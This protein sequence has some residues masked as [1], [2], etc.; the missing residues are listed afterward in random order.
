MCCDFLPQEKGFDRSLFF[1]S[2]A[3]F[4]S[5]TRCDL[6]LNHSPLCL[7]VGYRETH[8]TNEVNCCMYYCCCAAWNIRQLLR[9]FMFCPVALGPYHATC[10]FPN[11][12]LLYWTH[13]EGTRE[14][15][16]KEAATKG[17]R[18]LYQPQDRNNSKSILHNSVI[19]DTCLSSQTNSTRVTTAVTLLR[20]TS[21]LLMA[22]LTA[23]CCS[24]FLRISARM[25]SMSSS[26]ASRAS[27][28]ISLDE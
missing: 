4:E 3:F 19:P 18:H 2:S 14:S 8:S 23:V 15:S 7:S 9:C 6:V 26:P 16:E 27:C 20:Y 17:L 10:T 22:A 21:F 28:E 1:F 13:H 24:S 5:Y 25:A 11:C 12:T